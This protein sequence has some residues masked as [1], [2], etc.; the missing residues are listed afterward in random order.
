MEFLAVLALGLVAGTVGGLVG[1]GTSI[2]LM[3][4]LVIV[5]G[6]REAVPIMAIASIMGNASRVAAWW[7]EVDWRATLAYSVTAIP[8][9][10]LG[11][12]TLLSLPVGYVEAAMGLFFIVMIPVRRWMARQHWKLTAWQLSIV[13]AGIGFLTGLVV[14]TGPINAPF[15]LMYGLVKGGY[16]ATEALSSV[17]VYLA[18]AITFRSMGALPLAIIGKGVIV[19]CSLVGGAFFA[20]R[21]VRQLDAQRFRALMD[22]LLL[23]AG[24]TMLW[25]AWRALA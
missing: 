10:V 18:K 22:G 17:A 14:S 9:A 1:F 3:P 23:V 5:F 13:G 7:R 25:A 21:F 4:A 15:F 8:A 12:T 24:L 11:A 19:G 2:M 16:L 20:K 6:P